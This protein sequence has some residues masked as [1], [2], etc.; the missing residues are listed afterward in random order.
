[1]QMVNEMTRKFKNLGIPFFGISSRL[2]IPVGKGE[3][4]EGDGGIKLEKGM[5]H[6][7]DLVALQKRMLVFLEEMHSDH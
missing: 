2:V 1:M 4:V 6:E 3:V 5:L 7:L